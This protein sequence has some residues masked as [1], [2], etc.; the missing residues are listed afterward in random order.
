MGM[1]NEPTD[2]LNNILTVTPDTFQ[3]DLF[4]NFSWTKKLS[5]KSDI[6]EAAIAEWIR[7][8]LPFPGLNPK[9]PLIL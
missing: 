4:N 2:T 8:R 5:A 9:P 3:L 6:Q 1:G 7:L